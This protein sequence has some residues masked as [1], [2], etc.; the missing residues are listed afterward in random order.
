MNIKDIAIV[1]S[2]LLIGY[3]V[4]VCGLTALLDVV[5]NYL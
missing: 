2:G 5:A 4:L 3:V 1:T